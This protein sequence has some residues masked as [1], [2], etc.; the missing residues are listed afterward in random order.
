MDDSFIRPSILPKLALCGHY[1]SAPAG[2]AAARGTRID[3]LFRFLISGS[4]EPDPRPGADPDELR[5]AD[6]MA[7]TARVF[8]GREPL[9]ATEEGCAIECDVGLSRPLTGTGDLVCPTCQ[10]SADAK[11]GQRRDYRAQQAAYA[12]GYMEKYFCDEWTVRLFY[13]DEETTEALYFTRESAMETVHDA[14]AL[15]RAREIPTPNE[16]CGWCLNRFDCPA[17]REALGQWLTPLDLSKSPPETLGDKDTP[18]LLSFAL[19]IRDLADWDEE[20]RRLIKLRAEGGE[21]T[22]GVKLVPKRGSRKVEPFTLFGRIEPATILA[23]CAPISEAKAK[24]LFPDLEDDLVKEAPGRV[25]LHLS[26]P[27]K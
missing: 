22:V 13:C 6:W 15:W 20:A 25:E 16:Y 26:R 5:A 17:R 2:E 3:T 4:G 9:D 24:E 1:R 14:L 7:C 21:K 11:S 8:A 27:K 19:M 12:L 18:A 23:A 10:W